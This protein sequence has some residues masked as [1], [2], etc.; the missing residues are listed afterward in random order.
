MLSLVSFGLG[1][2]AAA[3]WMKSPAP[4][5]TGLDAS[6]GQTQVEIPPPDTGPTSN[7]D[8]TVLRPENNRADVGVNAPPPPARSAPGAQPVPAEAT[9][10]D[11][12]A[13]GADAD[14][15]AASDEVA[16]LRVLDRYRHAY[17]RM[18]VSAVA[19]VW[20]LADRRALARAFDGVTSQELAYERCEVSVEP[21]LAT[22]Y[23]QG[24]LLSEK[25]AGSPGRHQAAPA[26]HQWLF[27]LRQRGT[28]WKIEKVI[29]SPLSAQVRL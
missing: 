10:A 23:C 9:R 18:D 27:R 1:I 17:G 11:A 7:G 26:R 12:T 20:P 28:D 2:A 15:P 14:P 5:P 24:T 8:V 21:P 6:I 25:A 3:W 29:A 22:A 16:I 19:D 4:M 13:D